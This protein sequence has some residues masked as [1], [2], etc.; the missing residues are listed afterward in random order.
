MSIFCSRGTPSQR[1]LKMAPTPNTLSVSDHVWSVSDDFFRSQHSNNG[2]SISHICHARSYVQTQ[3]FAHK[4]VHGIW[5]HTPQAG[6][7]SALRWWCRLGRT[8]PPS[9]LARW[10]LRPPAGEQNRLFNCRDLYHTSVDS[11]ERQCRSRTWERRFDPALRTG[12]VQTGYGQLVMVGRRQ[13]VPAPERILAGRC[14]ANVAR[15]T[16]AKPDSGLDFQV[17]V[18]TAFQVARRTPPRH[19]PSERDQ[20]DFFRPWFELAL[21]AIRRRVVQIKTIG[22]HG[23]LP[24]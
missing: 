10:P 1:R 9:R 12:D 19:Q 4:V 13:P 23:L 11:G 22:K 17:K 6:A 18:L 3:H 7:A 24:L 20:T 14:R 15:E 8:A 16:Q 2:L 5:G 21:A